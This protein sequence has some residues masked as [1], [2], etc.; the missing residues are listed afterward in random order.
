MVRGPNNNDASAAT[1]AGAA[2]AT[3]V[4]YVPRR[5]YYHR[6]TRS[7]FWEMELMLPVGNHPARR[8]AP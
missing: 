4:E 7:M 5:D 3:R 8:A 2:G 1:V 6:H